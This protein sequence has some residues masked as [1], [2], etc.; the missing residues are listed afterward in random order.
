MTKKTI[1]ALRDGIHEITGRYPVSEDREY[2]ERR[3]AELEK[4][5]DDGEAA[6]DRYKDSTTV[7]SVSMRGAA[8]DA[9]IRIAGGEKV[10]VSELVRR[11]LAMYASKYGYGTE[12]EHFE[13]EG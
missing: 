6:G 3:L 10:S 5:H 1:N 2:L 8:K 13:I 9:T 11:S 4:R 7:L 12:V